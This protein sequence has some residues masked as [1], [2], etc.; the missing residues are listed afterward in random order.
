V[1]TVMMLFP[2]QVMPLMK[3][4]HLLLECNRAAPVRGF[5]D[6]KY[7]NPSFGAPMLA[8]YLLSGL[9][10]TAH[11]PKVCSFRITSGQSDDSWRL[12]IRTL[13]M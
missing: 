10:A 5:I 6:H 11:T 9:K 12:K 8:R 7:K 4:V 3:L 2:I 1:P 13:G